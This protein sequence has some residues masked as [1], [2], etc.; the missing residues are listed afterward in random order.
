MLQLKKLINVVVIKKKQI[1]AKYLRQIKYTKL[2]LD[3]DAFDVS[4]K[5]LDLNILHPK[6]RDDANHIGVAVANGCDYVVSWNFKHMVNIKTIN[7]IR[8]IA[9]L[10]GYKYIDL[11]SP[12]YFL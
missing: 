5:I 7:V 12:S 4:D 2:K 11:V 3:N 6:S 10:N 9:N 1:F 8:A